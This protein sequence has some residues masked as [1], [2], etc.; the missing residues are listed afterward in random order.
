M[1]IDQARYHRW[2]GNLR[3]PWLASLAIVGVAV[4][5]VLR[6][7]FYWIVLAL[8][9]SQFL[10]FWSI[11]YIVTQL[12]LPPDAQELI[13][14]RFGFSASTEDVHDSGYLRF[15]EQQ[16]VVVLILL[17]FSGSLLVGADFRLKSLPFYLSRRIERR[18]YI[19]AKLL[20]VSSLIAILTLIPALLLFLEYG[21]FTSSLAYWLD[22]WRVPLA[23]LAYGAVVC[24]VSSTLLV[25]LSAYLQRA[26]PIAITWASLFFLP[27]RLAS[28]LRDAT[29]DEH[30]RLIDLW[31]DMRLV[32]KLCF[33]T[34]PKSTV[35]GELA[36]WALL[37]LS[38]LC[39]IALAALIHRVRA[40][41]IRE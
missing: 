3:S 2:E 39:A 1:G 33:G 8:G 6:R 34:P 30:W 41:D 20:A 28:Y 27:G 13:F 12:K 26:A 38:L 14:E 16:S 18:H 5:Q 23:I 4:R 24:A 25:S 32:G 35:D 37:I 17:A 21:M 40:V 31:R 7:K 11:I 29:G 9:L 15:M 19:V 36:W 22:N 10:L